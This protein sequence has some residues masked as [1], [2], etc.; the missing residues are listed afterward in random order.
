[1]EK[2]KDFSK[3][4]NFP[5]KCYKNVD[6]SL[7]KTTTSKENLCK[8]NAKLNGGFYVKVWIVCNNKCDKSVEKCKLR[9]KSVWE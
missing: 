1:M 6:F 3:W 4:A 7:C 9:H 8:L 2:A 5:K